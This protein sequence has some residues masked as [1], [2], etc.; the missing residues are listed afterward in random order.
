VLAVVT[1][2][3][4]R[5]LLL[6]HRFRGGLPWGLPGGWL[7]PGE[8]PRSGMCRELAEELGLEVAPD[9]LR[10]IEAT[11]RPGTSHIEVFYGLCVE[12]LAV[13]ECFEFTNHGWFA[14]AELPRAM[15]DQHRRLLVGLME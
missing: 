9:E 11:S 15:V 2:P 1:D 6:E 13:P 5:V 7:E 12:T 10:L 8:A 14:A 3:A 4:G